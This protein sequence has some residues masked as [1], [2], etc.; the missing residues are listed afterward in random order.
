MT[1]TN[2]KDPKFCHPTIQENA[3]FNLSILLLLLESLLIQIYIL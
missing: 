1:T 3:D 2:P